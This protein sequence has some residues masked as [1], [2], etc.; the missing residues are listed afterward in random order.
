M[1]S[2]LVFGAMHHVA[3]RYLLVKLLPGQFAHSIDRI[4]ASRKQQTMFSGVLLFE[5]PRPNSAGQTATA[6]NCGSQ[7]D[8][9]ASNSERPS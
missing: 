5:I 7:A 6:L 2:E 3:N 4:P 9:R 1:R 8:E